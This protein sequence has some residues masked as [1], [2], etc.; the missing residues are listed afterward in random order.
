MLKR[1][2]TFNYNYNIMKV[3]R[4]IVNPFRENTNILW[5][6]KTREAAIVDPG[7]YNDNERKAI[8]DFVIKNK[9]VLK[10]LL[11]T[12]LHLDHAFAGKYIKDK[13]NLEYETSIEENL[14]LEILSLK[15][16]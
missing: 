16:Q 15:A 6:E 7:M 9:L 11:F 4:F 14:L 12:H 13:Y 2:F 1:L 10:H 3:S 5:D 8:D